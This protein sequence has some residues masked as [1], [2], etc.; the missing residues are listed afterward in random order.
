MSKISP[1]NRFPD[2]VIKKSVTCQPQKIEFEDEESYHER[3]VL[4]CEISTR[5][6]LCVTKG[7]EKDTIIVFS[8][9]SVIIPNYYNPRCTDPV[10]MQY[11]FPTLGIFSWVRCLKF[12]GH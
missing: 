7:L 10:Q 3:S 6:T 1:E 9:K 12:W 8:Y 4:L 11:E 5:Q 2:E